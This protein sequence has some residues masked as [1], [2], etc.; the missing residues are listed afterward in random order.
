VLQSVLL[1]L[2]AG[3]TSLAA[4]LSAF[5]VSRACGKPVFLAL[6]YAAATFTAAL[7]LAL[8]ALTFVENAVQDHYMRSHGSHALASRPIMT[9]SGALDGAVCDFR[10]TYVPIAG[11]ALLQLLCC[12]PA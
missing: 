10:A 5:I 7:T 9:G 3:A 4:G 8:L 12:E 2:L 11:Y 1:V 6:C